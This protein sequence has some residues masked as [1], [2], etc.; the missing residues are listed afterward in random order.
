M[1]GKERNR[2]VS[3]A[4]QREEGII[5]WHPDEPMSQFRTHI[6]LYFPGEPGKSQTFENVRE[7]TLGTEHRI[8]FIAEDGKSI[9]T[10]LPFFLERET[11][12]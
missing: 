9:S 11:K 3:P 8:H 6:T 10:S 5:S 7:Y 2:F 1:L 4:S 12:K